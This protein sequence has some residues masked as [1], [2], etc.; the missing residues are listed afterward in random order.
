MPLNMAISVFTSST[1]D[2]N[3]QLE[4]KVLLMGYVKHN[5][6]LDPPASHP[7]MLSKPLVIHHAT[8][9]HLDC[10]RYVE[11][12]AYVFSV[13]TAMRWDQSRHHRSD[14]HFRLPK[15]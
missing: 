1:M 6:K 4:S 15:I 2:F 12:S 5:C 10:S 8:G 3:L 9:I 7:F 14:I 13:S 11:L